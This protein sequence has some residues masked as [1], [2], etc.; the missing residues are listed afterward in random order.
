MTDAA[1]RIPHTAT[2]LAGVSGGA[3]SIYLVRWLQVQAP[4]R[5]WKI[6]IG[7]V[8]HGTRGEASDEDEA[9][10]REFAAT[11]KL[12][13]FTYRAEADTED[14]PRF[15]ENRLRVLRLEALRE[16]ARK[17]GASVLALGHHRDDLAETFL[18]NALRGSGPAGLEGMRPVRRLSDGL[19]LF[20]PL[21][22]IKKKA[23]EE[24]LRQR[25][26]PWRHDSSNDEV[27]YLRNRLRHD[28]LPLLEQIEPGSAE[29]FAASAEF[30]G[31]VFGAY[32][33][34]V[35]ERAEDLVLARGKQTRLFSIP[36]IRRPE[37]QK[38][39]FGLVRHLF[40]EVFEEEQEIRI[41]PVLPN[42]DTMRNLKRRLTERKAGEANFRLG[43][44]ISLSVTNQ[45]G[46]IYR[47]GSF[48]ES[49]LRVAN[50]FP[51]LLIPP[52]VTYRWPLSQVASSAIPEY[53]EGYSCDFEVTS[54]ERLY[55]PWDYANADGEKNAF[56]DLG[57][58]QGDLEVRALRPRE[59]L[60]YPGGNSKSVRDCLQEAGVPPRLRG[61]IAGLCDTKGILWIPGIRRVAR[62][63]INDQ[64][65]RVLAVRQVPKTVRR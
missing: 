58:L 21:L 14:P 64:T 62:A 1:E 8:N 42:R 48:E 40:E 38:L 41:N 6:L 27:A 33:Q 4:A 16:M 12:P 13:F 61:M 24:D 36:R 49:V 23:I 19:V 63:W 35:S 11:C 47:G 39:I 45:Y 52:H 50:G 31:E 17:E 44:G 22:D 51:F 59:R 30:C 34:L 56:F 65:E 57:A 53:L 54:D 7:H 20:R 25:N 9:F 43:E 2:I 60:E 32:R 26:Q 3:D 46:L 15:E 10:V 5:D 55:A 37:N 28:V 18:I 29:N